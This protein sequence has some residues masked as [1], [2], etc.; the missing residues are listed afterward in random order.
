MEITTELTE[1][2]KVI[3]KAKLEVY[4]KMLNKSHDLQYGNLSPEYFTTIIE[5]EIELI[6]DKLKEPKKDPGKIEV[7]KPK[8]GPG[9]T[10]RHTITDTSI[11]FTVMEVHHGSQ[12]YKL[13]SNNQI[14]PVTVMVG[15]G[16]LDEN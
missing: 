9:D 7:I 12:E 6:E 13:T 15:W 10:V 8:Y 2:E 16:E 5:R 4:E 14:K 3:L 1:R 11:L